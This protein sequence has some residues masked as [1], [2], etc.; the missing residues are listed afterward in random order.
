MNAKIVFSFFQTVFFNPPYNKVTKFSG[1]FSSFCAVTA[2]SFGIMD[3]SHKHSTD[4]LTG[5]WVT[6]S[7]L[8]VGDKL[9]AKPF[10]LE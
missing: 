8:N 10:E 5:A 4:Q 1:I 9:Q 2:K 6:E 7:W 3:D